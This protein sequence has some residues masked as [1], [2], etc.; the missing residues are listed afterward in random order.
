[1][2]MKFNKSSQLLLVS[3]ASLLV[4]GLITACGTLTVDFVY[5]ASSK[6]AGPNNYGQIDVFEINSESGVMRQIPS[7]PF[8]S[9]GRDPVAEAVSSD[10]NNLFV[11]NQ[12]DDTIVQFVIGNDGKLYP[13][14]T[15]NTP[16]V[17]PLAVAVNGMNLFI[18]NTY[19]PLPTCST[20]QPCSSSISVYPLAAGGSAASDPCPATVCI[21]APAV[22]TSV[23]AAYWPLILPTSHSDVI[24]ATGIYVLPAG[25]YVYVAAYDATTQSNY[26][27]GFAIGTGGVLTPLHGGAPLGGGAFAVES[28]TGV[29][30]NAPYIVGTCPSAITS[31]SSSS[32]VYVTDVANG[33]V[34]GYSVASG[35]GLLTSLSGNPFRAGDQP[36]ALVADPSYPYLYVTNSLDSTVSAYSMDNGAL[37]SIGTYGTGLEPV[38]IGIDPSTNHFLYTANYLGNA[39]TSGTVNGFELSPTAGT[40]VNSQNSPY[41]SNAQ[42]TA[43]AAISH[44]GTGAG[45]Q[46]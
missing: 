35:T 30:L 44:N 10:Y 9:G 43:V 36:N 26:I 11:A 16:G 23:N 29:F 6:A 34:L 1:M 21:G 14:N 5:V 15:V 39:L 20:A 3:A 7:S 2:R 17:Y 12:I 32:Y 18:V 40:L 4:A 25:N 45:V 28:C 13:T 8:P 46:K 42:P 31:D 27:F 19:Q 37:T 33:K 24:E 41:V 38:A 22:N